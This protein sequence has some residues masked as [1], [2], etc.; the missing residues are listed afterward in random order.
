MVL[1]RHQQRPRRVR[2]A[3]PPELRRLTASSA[4]RSIPGLRPRH[5]RHRGRGTAS[6]QADPPAEPD[7]EDPRHRRG[8]SGDQADDR[9]GSQH[10][11][12]PDLQPRP[13]PGG[14]GGVHRRPRAVRRAARRRPVQGGQR[15]QLLHQ[16]CRHRDRQPARQHRLPRGAGAARQGRGRPGQARLPAVPA[17]VQR[18]AVGR[19]GRQGRSACSGRCGPAPRRRT[20]PIP[21]RCTSTS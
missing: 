21:T 11:R 18:P 16:P 1:A 19:A 2:P 7:G 8:R 5:G 10:Q 12:H 3:V 4:S 9:R 15:R 13:V 6:A 20:P 17:D 14:D